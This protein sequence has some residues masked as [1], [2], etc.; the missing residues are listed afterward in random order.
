[1]NVRAGPILR[2]AGLLI[3]MICVFALVTQKDESQVVAGVAVRS[4]WIAGIV[5]GVLV[6]GVGLV[7]VQLAA[8]RPRL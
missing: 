5:L 6:W 8:R 1:M 7:L 4:L 3:E 2:F